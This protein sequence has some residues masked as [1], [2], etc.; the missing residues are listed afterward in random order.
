MNSFDEKL[1][2]WPGAV[3]PARPVRWF[4]EAFDVHSIR[5]VETPVSLSYNFVLT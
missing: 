2:Q 5:K 3:R 4:A 1:L